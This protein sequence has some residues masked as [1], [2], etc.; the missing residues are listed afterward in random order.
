MALSVDAAGDVRYDAIINKNDKIV[1]H[2]HSQLV[3]K[4]DELR[5]DLS[6]P[7]KEEEDEA[8][9]KTQAALEK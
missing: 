3:P 7:T 9:K 2:S 4:I 6:R 8:A 1:Y 5:S